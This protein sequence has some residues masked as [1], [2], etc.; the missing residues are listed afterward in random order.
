MK[1]AK[2]ELERLEAELLAQEEL[3]EEAEPQEETEDSPELYRNY[4]NHYRAY[5]TDRA[6]WD[7]D[8]LSEELEQPPKPGIWGLVAVALLLTAAI[9][10]LLAWYVRRNGGLL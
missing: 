3:E 5:N 8:E 7:P 10:L 2:K 4:S 1:D 6:D 9:F